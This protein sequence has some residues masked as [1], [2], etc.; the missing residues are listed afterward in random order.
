MSDQEKTGNTSVQDA[1]QQT[2]ERARELNEQILQS[3]RKTGEQMLDGY[4]SWLEMVAEQQRKLAATPQVS[5]MDWIA[6]MLNAQADFTRKFA[7]LVREL[8][9][10]TAAAEGRPTFVDTVLN[11]FVE[12]TGMS[13]DDQ[14][15]DFIL[16]EVLESDAKWQEAVAEGRMDSDQV[17]R[18]LAECLQATAA[19]AH[20][21][22]ILDIDEAR[23]AF[24]EVIHDRW[25]CPF[26]LIFC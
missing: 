2:L 24:Y 7:G 8:R 22:G 14:V 13:V 25:N 15:R 11:D 19:V 21:S 5:Q 1:L 9:T 12:N 3:A 20:D 18:I 17:H 16:D 6:A 26:P 23:P 4:V 10:A